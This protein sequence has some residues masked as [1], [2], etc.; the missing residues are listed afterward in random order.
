MLRQRAIERMAGISAMVQQP[1]HL[2]LR[3]SAQGEMAN[4]QKIQQC[5]LI[6]LVQPS[7]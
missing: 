5:R 2:T 6:V 7:A 4:S 1:M 3:W